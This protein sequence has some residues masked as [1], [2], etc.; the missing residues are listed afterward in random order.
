[1]PKEHGCHPDEHVMG[2]LSRAGHILRNPVNNILSI[3][4]S[5]GARDVG[6][7]GPWS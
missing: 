2:P 7:S 3:V 1:M 6:C 4:E 5:P